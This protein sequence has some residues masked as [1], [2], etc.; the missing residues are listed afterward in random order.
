MLIESFRVLPRGPCS[1][2]R[3]HVSKGPAAPWPR[4]PL[5]QRARRAFVRG[6]AAAEQGCSDPAGLAK[7]A[8]RSGVQAPLLRL[9]DFS[10]LRGMAAS[11]DI[12]VDEPLASLPKDAA[13]LVVPKMPC[14]FPELCSPELWDSSP[15][16]FKMAL[17]LLDERNKG[18][19]SRLSGYVEQ[20]PKT[21]DTPLHW[22][23]AELADLQVSPPSLSPLLPPPCSSILP[24]SSSPV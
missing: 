14:P 13:L 19:T 12:E 6:A 11:R 24:P 7:W 4:A 15:W 1:L 17:L 21:L 5:V 23:D 9:A 20:L 16:W 2:P 8:E 22:S 3:T 10:G 18:E